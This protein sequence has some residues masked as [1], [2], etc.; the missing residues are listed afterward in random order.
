MESRQG[1]LLRHVARKGALVFSGVAL[2]LVLRLVKNIVI[3]RILAPELRGIWGLLN[4]MPTF[5]VSAGNMGIGAAI[6]YYSGK[7]LY[8]DRYTVGAALYSTLLCGSLLGAVAFFLIGQGLF[9]EGN[10]HLLEPYRMLIMLITPVFWLQLMANSYFTGTSL[11]GR[12][13][14]LRILESALPLVLFLVFYFGLAMESLN[15]ATYSWF[16]GFAVLGLTAIFML[17]LKEN[18]PPLLSL[19]ACRDMLWF[20]L[21]GHLGNFCNLIILRVDILFISYYLTPKDLGYYMIATSV[22]ELLMMLPESLLIPFT[23][24]LFG[25]DERDSQAFS[26]NALRVVFW[27]MLCIC[28]ATML[29]SWPLIF[30]MFGQA[31]L[32]AWG[33]TLALVPGMLFLSLFYVLKVDMNNRDKPGATSMVAGLAALVNILL[34]WAF[35]PGFGITAAAL[36]STISYGICAVLLLI[37]YARFSKMSLLYIFTVNRREMML[38]AAKVRARVQTLLTRG[39]IR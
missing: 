36:A 37:L 29:V 13:T 19:K 10:T 30:I 25:A 18:F 3:S 2:V 34:N 39:G 28:L 22:A 8:D 17:P 26:R 23:S 6:T 35:I 14:L 9:F 4:V 16:W 1:K 27:G 33:C 20:G 21:R 5:L 12:L 11:V 32:P 24:T 7:K 15:A 31:Y 38:I